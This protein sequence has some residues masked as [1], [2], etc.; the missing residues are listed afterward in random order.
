MQNKYTG[1]VVQ[2]KEFV[3]LSLC[4]YAPATICF[5]QQNVLPKPMGEKNNQPKKQI[6]KY[7]QIRKLSSSELESENLFKSAPLFL[8]AGLGFKVSRLS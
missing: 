6:L 1:V 5:S 8:L 2:K 7:P 4:D 3:K